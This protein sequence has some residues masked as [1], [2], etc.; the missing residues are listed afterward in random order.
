MGVNLRVRDRGW[1]K[2]LGKLAIS[3]WVAEE[4]EILGVPSAKGR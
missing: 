2:T 1:N 3:S 4:V